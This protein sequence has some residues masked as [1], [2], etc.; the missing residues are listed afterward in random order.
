MSRAGSCLCD[1]ISFD[2]E[3]PLRNVLHCHCVNCQKSSGNYVASSGCPT[4]KLTINDP[5]EQLRWYDM[6]YC[7]YGFCATCGSRM[8]WQGAEH[9]HH[10]SIQAGVLDDAS[11]LTLDGIWFADD[12]QPHVALNTEVPH[13]SGNGSES[14]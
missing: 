6:G 1:A 9:M 13:H 2:V 11:G 10:T 14:P 5:T 7:R 4:N 3:G 8:F 12:A